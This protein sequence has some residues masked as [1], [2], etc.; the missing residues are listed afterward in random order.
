M[1]H[2]GAVTPISLTMWANPRNIFVHY[3]SVYLSAS[4]HLTVTQTLPAVTYNCVLVLQISASSAGYTATISRRSFFY[5]RHPFV[6]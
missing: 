6:F 3:G 5:T 4:R 1:Q 2:A